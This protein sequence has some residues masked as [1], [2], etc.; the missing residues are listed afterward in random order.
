[1]DLRFCIPFC[2]LKRYSMSSYIALSIASFA[3]TDVAALNG[4]LGGTETQ[5]NILI[6]SAA[7]LARSGALGLGLRVLEDMGLLLEST[8]RLDGQLGRP[9]ILLA[10]KW[11]EMSRASAVRT[12]ILNDPL[13]G[14][15]RCKR[16]LSWRNWRGGC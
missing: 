13:P 12:D 11:S 9:E 4:R 7:T 14:R 5:P 16:A 8:L 6:P 3:R 2:P 15:Y 1:M 10:S